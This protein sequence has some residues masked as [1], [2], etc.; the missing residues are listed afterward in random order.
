MAVRKEIEALAAQS[1]MQAFGWIETQEIEFYPE[2]RALCQGNACRNYG[3]SWACPPAVG[4][5]AQCRE[6][7]M[8]YGHMLLFSAAYALEDCFD[9]EGMQAGMADF[10]DK[11]D[12]FGC[13]LAGAAE[14]YF[15]FSNE[16][17]GRCASCT[18]PHA[19][20]RFPERLYPSLEGYGLI[21]SELARQASVRYQNGVNT[22]TFF[23]A[24]LI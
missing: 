2:V 9:L 8:Q 19:P 7:V 11:V 12:R 1:G 10:K 14:D 6:R 16:G 17:C 5:L 4:T 3:T 13:A 23:G 24:L 21:V 15:L 22:V 18:Y 20:C